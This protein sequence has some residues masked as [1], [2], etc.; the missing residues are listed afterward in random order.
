MPRQVEG[1]DAEAPGDLGIVQ[2]AEADL[3]DFGFNDYPELPKALWEVEILSDDSS[4]MSEGQLDDHCSWEGDEFGLDAEPEAMSGAVRFEPC[5]EVI[6]VEIPVD[7]SMNRYRPPSED[8]IYRMSE[9][10]FR[11]RARDTWTVR[12]NYLVR[13]HNTPRKGLFM[14]G[15]RRLP[16]GV[17]LEHVGGDR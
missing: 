15:A 12:H 16:E 2:R 10:Y 6:E 1:N 7:S 17:T 5:S 8:R 9:R 3:G 13:C 11:P 4:R 14:L